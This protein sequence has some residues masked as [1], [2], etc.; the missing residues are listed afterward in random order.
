M[1]SLVWVRIIWVSI[2]MPKIKN[3]HLELTLYK[4]RLLNGLVVNVI[5][6]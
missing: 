4:Q 2:K 3:M 5:K 6:I 1:N